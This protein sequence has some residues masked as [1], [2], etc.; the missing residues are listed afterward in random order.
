MSQ[1]RNLLICPVPKK[2]TAE[3]KP[4]SPNGKRILLVED[5]ALNREIAQTILE[6]AGFAVETADDGKAAVEKVEQSAPGQ[7][8]L[9]LMDIQMRL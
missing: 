9:I 8:D 7:Y 4:I 6:D 2:E 1:L 3:A 5:N